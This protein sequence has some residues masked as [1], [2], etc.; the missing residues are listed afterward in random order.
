MR[1]K[2]ILI[3]EDE[4]SI[5]EILSISLGDIGFDIKAVFTAEDGLDV[6]KKFKPDLI[7]LDLM[8]PR[9]SG[10]EFCR[11]IDEEYPI[12]MLTA[13]NKISDKLNGLEIGADDYIIKPFDIREVILRVKNILRRGERGKKEL[14]FVIDNEKRI[15]KKDGNIIN[16]NRKEFEVLKLF[17][18][19]K[20]IV[21]T[22]EK[23]L[24]SIWGY[25][26]EG[27]DRT[28]DVHIRRLRKK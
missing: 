28:V 14:G 11:V 4:V 1:K 24:T 3:I 25:D 12:I 23:L 6:V 2:K 27:S 17:N 13:K 22:R 20:D 21:F 8:L 19:N 10:E 16:L 26:Y 15:V 7:L 9:M 5:N 18:E